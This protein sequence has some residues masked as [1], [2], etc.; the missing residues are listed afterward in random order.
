[1][2]IHLWQ[3]Y[4]Y[5]KISVNITPNLKDKIKGLIEKDIYEISH[6]IKIIPARLYDYFIYQTAP[7]PLN[8][9]ME[10]SKLINISLLEIEKNIVMY[11]QM[12]VP[13]KNSIKNPKLP[14]EINPY[15][16]SIIANLYFDGS[17][18][19]DGKGTYYN[20]KDEKIMDDFVN[21]LKYVFGDVQYSVIKDHRG[22]LKCR[23]PRIIGEICKSIYEIDS[24]GTFDSRV[25]PKIF[26]LSKEHK[27]AFV[28]TAI[29]DEGS[30]T[31]DGQIFFGVNNQLLCGDIKELC[32][33]IGLETN[34]VRQKSK[35][36]HY[37]IYIKSKDKLLGIINLLKKDYP[38]ISLRYKELRLKHYFEIKR[39]PGLRTKKGGDERK[40][41]ILKSL[42]K[43]EKTSNQLS[44][45]LFILPRVLRRHLSVLL[46]EKKVIRKKISNEYYYSL[47]NPH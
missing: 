31:Y 36:N 29:L 21:K 43:K 15:F 32:N 24:F 14:I 34:P 11:K 44:E 40:N 35:S 25:S 19:K 28:L 26:K 37:Y 18:P 33:Q 4:N 13:N 42:E 17:V 30:I 41:K 39:Y 22:V 20:Q 27:I 5:N 10:L 6:R 45:Q 38:L 16:T 3:A 1:M 7:I 12:F 23:V 8:V 9:L 2:K 46:K 47:T